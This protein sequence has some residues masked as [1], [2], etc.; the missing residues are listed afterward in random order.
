MLF[1]VA[2]VDPNEMPTR[3][4]IVC[5]RLLFIKWKK[6]EKLNKKYRKNGSPNLCLQLGGAEMHRVLCL[7][8]LSKG[9]LPFDKEALFKLL[10]DCSSCS[11]SL[12]LNNKFYGA[13]TV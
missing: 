1:M 9:N 12:Q 7:T 11:S 2:P 8:T 10:H 13:H 4:F 6:C 3:G 5:P